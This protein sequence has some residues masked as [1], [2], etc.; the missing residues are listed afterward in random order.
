MINRIR[1]YVPWRAFFDLI[2]RCDEYVIFDQVQYAKRHWHNRNRIKT[3]AGLERLTIPVIS[4]GRF[5]QPIDEVEIEKPW[6]E[7]HWRAIELAYV[8][9]PFFGMLAP[10]VQDCVRKARPPPNHCSSQAWQRPVKEPLPCRWLPRSACSIYSNSR[11]TMLGRLSDIKGLFMPSTKRCR[12]SP[13][14]VLICVSDFTATITRDP[15]AGKRSPASVSV[16]SS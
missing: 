2:G 16:T 4:K 14:P 7:K 5:E 6:A 8:R 3:A 10:T 1:Y 9:A 12:Q 13:R 15:P 11:P